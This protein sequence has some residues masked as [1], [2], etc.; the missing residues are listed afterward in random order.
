MRKYLAM[1]GGALLAIVAFIAQAF[2]LKSAKQKLDNTKLK[3]KQAKAVSDSVVT[4]VE[5]LQKNQAESE[6]RIDEA[7]KKH[8]SV[9]DINRMLDD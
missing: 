1:A 7:S 8:F 5:E 6:K 2:A 3:L 9:D 4:Q